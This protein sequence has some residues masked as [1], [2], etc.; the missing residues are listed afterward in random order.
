MMLSE[1]DKEELIR[2]AQ[3][4]DAAIIEK[5]NA[6][7][8]KRAPSLD[9]MREAAAAGSLIKEL[10]K[11]REERKNPAFDNPTDEQRREI[12]QAIKDIHDSAIL[13]S[14]SNKE[15]QEALSEAFTIDRHAVL[16]KRHLTLHRIVHAFAHEEDLA[17]DFNKA[18]TEF[19]IVR[20]RLENSLLYEQHEDY[21]FDQLPKFSATTI[22]DKIND[23]SVLPYFPP[24]EAKVVEEEIKTRNLFG[25]NENPL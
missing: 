17:D 7:R 1:K 20:Y 24:H 3:P 5:V 18:I 9:K 22:F 4:T 15:I 16:G 2:I 13:S 19:C 14:S 10:L 8:V 11:G 23:L 21:V 6:A 12:A 25:T